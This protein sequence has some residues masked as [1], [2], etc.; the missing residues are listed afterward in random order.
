MRVVEREFWSSVTLDYS[1]A[2]VIDLNSY[3]LLFSVNHMLTGCCELYLNYPLMLI[4]NQIPYLNQSK[5]IIQTLHC[6]K[7]LGGDEENDLFLNPTHQ[8]TPLPFLTKD[9]LKENML[10]LFMKFHDNHDV[11][12]QTY[13]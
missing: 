10:Y 7:G 4:I 12:R 8:C 2:L 5:S 13:K 6:Y 9:T 1:Y 11:G 3:C